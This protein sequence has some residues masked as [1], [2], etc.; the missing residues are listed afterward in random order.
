M[1][2]RTLVR[3]TKTSAIF[4]R[5]PRD[6]HL[7]IHVPV[8]TGWGEQECKIRARKMMERDFPDESQMEWEAEIVQEGER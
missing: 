8:S 1:N 7:D 2:K 3:L 4:G 6:G 5:L